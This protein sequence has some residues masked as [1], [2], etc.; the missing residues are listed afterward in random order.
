MM[1][2]GLDRRLPILRDQELLTSIDGSLAALH[3]SQQSV[4]KESS[5]VSSK[6]G[7]IQ[8]LALLLLY[9]H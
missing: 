3:D 4:K 6:S 7:A 5:D 1:T 9:F 8:R 2:V